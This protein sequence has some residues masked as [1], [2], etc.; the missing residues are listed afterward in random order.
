VVLPNGV[1]AAETN[2]ETVVASIGGRMAEVAET[3]V[4]GAAPAEAVAP[5]PAGE[6]KT[7]AEG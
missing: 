6:G 3:P 1:R 4:E 2:L 7:G 5:A